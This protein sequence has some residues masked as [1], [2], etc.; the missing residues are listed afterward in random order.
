MNIQFEDLH[1][2]SHISDDAYGSMLEK[3]EKA[4][5]YGFTAIGF[6]DHLEI[7][8]NWG[9]DVEEYFNAL[10]EVRRVF[11]KRLHIYS[12]VE[13]GFTDKRLPLIQEHLQHYQ[14]DYVIGSIHAINGIIASEMKSAYTSH[15]HI[16]NMYQQYFDMIYKTVACGLFDII[17]H[18]NFIRRW[19]PEEFQAIEV[20]H[21]PA[22]S[23]RLDMILDL[24]IEKKSILE[25]NCASLRKGYSYTLPEEEIIARYAQ[26]G[27]TL[28]SYASDTHIP[29]DIGTGIE[30]YS[31][32]LARY[33]LTSYS[34]RSI[35]ARL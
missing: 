24:I 25:I 9:Y 3:A 31:S 22:L 4:L 6:A 35:P 13:I 14:Y 19:I 33:N 20:W 11:D 16:M 32:L 26:R 29:D 7:N 10:N 2:H 12:S 18:I 1:I 27:G 34:P 30:V 21:I 23:H 5:Q 8:S 17:A 15:E 28:V